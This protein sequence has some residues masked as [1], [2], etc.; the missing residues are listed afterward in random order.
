MVGFIMPNI[1]NIPI[2]CGLT[3]KLSKL[4]SYINLFTQWIINWPEYLLKYL[5][6]MLQMSI[7][8]QSLREITQIA[9]SI[10]V[11]QV[12][13]LSEVAVVS[14]GRPLAAFSSINVHQYDRPF[15]SV[16]HFPFV[17]FYHYV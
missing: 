13:F 9:I 12:T 5:Y 3:F 2:I 8:E 4:L 15:S 1:S 7:I 17:I 14:Y 11:I 10:S 6:R 16:H